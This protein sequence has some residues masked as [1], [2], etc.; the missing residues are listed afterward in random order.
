MTALGW[1][2][3]LLTG[4]PKAE[5]LQA[6]EVDEDFFST[7]GVAPI[8]GRPFQPDDFKSANSRIAIL[9]YSL[10]QQRFAGDP[11]LIGKT[12]LLD[13]AVHVVVGIMPEGFYPTRWETPRL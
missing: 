1:R 12:V 13:D 6:H 5:M 9:S 2:S 8:L 11:A 7:L 3:V 10:W 4:G